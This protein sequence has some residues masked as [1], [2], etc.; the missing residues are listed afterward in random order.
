[1]T[2]DCQTFAI[3]GYDT[4]KDCFDDN[5]DSEI[6]ETTSNTLDTGDI[7]AILFGTFIAVSTTAMIYCFGKRLLRRVN[8]FLAACQRAA[9]AFSFIQGPLADFLFRDD[10]KDTETTAETA[11]TPK[12][13]RKKE[14]R[15]ETATE[16]SPQKAKTPK[17]EHV[18]ITTEK[19]DRKKTKRVQIS[20]PKSKTV[21]VTAQ[22]EQDITTQVSLIDRFYND[23]FHQF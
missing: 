2:N 13:E 23:I 10:K 4:Q 20:T 7:L 17:Q 21:Q 3:L 14:T 22:I 16:K 18:E 8:R 15:D 6:R 1:M 11:K 9:N 12:S 5:Q 19:K